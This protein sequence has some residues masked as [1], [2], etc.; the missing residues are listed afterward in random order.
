MK[1]GQTS[2]L[3]ELKSQKGS[4]E[5]GNNKKTFP[6]LATCGEGCSKKD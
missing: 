3:S 2:N 5:N 1:T 6:S 4:G